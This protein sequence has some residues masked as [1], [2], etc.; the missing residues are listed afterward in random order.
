M[1]RRIISLTG[2][3]VFALFMFHYPEMSLGGNLNQ[4]I[5]L[6]QNLVIPDPAA[7]TDY[8]LA[9]I[10]SFQVDD[11]GNIYILDSRDLKVKVFA[12]S[13]MYLRTFGT[14]G[15]GPGEF[16]SPVDMF[17]IREGVLSVFDFGNKRISYYSMDGHHLE[18]IRLHELGGLFRPEA[19]DENSIYGN[20]IEWE[21]DGSQCLKLVRYDKTTRLVSTIS[22]V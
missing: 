5:Q 9:N 2:F 7:K 22:K 16:Q 15:Q 3:I 21:S 19:E 12:P 18:D 13:G 1:K 14:K 4:S 11:R 17:I 8:I 10:R 6:K 20:L